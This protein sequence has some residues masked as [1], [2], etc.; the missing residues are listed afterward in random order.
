MLHATSK[1][2]TKFYR[3]YLGHRDGE[4]RKVCEED[5][6]TSTLIGPMEF[7]PVLDV[8]Q[9]WKNILNHTD[10]R[11]FLP[12]VPPENIETT[13]WS[14]RK[15]LDDGKIIEPDVVV[16]LKW[17]NQVYNLLIEL[18][19]RAPLRPKD[20]L[21]RQWLQY[22]ASHE[23]T[24]SL[25][26]FIAPTVSEGAKALAEKDVWKGRLVLLPWM[27]VRDVLGKYSEEKTAIGRWAQL[28]DTFLA[29]VQ[30]LRFGGF[31]HLVNDANSLQISLPPTIFW[32]PHKFS[33]WGECVLPQG[34]QNTLPN[35]IFFKK[36]QGG[37]K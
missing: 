1:N 22:L 25:H 17:A 27:K 4:D 23:Q 18:K 3:R 13:L 7:L 6:I 12:N 26:L 5:E 37:I 2:K 19:W 34:L 32:Y 16:T 14:R 30:I 10:H 20:Q 29:H 15:A 33:G 11:D 24:Y 31:A 8:Y 21:H 28:V 35:P 9:F 36:S